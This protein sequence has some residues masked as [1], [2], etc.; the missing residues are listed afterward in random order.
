M[1]NG[2]IYHFSQVVHI[3]F[4]IIFPVKSYALYLKLLWGNTGVKIFD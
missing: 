2:K 4:E 3:C 1:S